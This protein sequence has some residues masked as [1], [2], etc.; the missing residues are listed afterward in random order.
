MVTGRY[1][2]RRIFL[3]KWLKKVGSSS[4]K[5]WYGAVD[6]SRLCDK[7]FNGIDLHD[8]KKLENEVVDAVQEV[9]AVD[10]SLPNHDLRPR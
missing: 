3:Q 6:C 8:E 10:F 5:S 4:L 2:E 9:S 1:D 7:T